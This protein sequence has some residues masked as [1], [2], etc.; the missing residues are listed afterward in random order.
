MPEDPVAVV[1]ANSAAFSARG[2]EAML[3]LDAPEGC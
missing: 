3:R 2:V 1:R